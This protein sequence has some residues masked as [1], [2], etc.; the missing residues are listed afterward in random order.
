MSYQKP[1]YQITLSI[2]KSIQDISQKLGEANTLNLDK[3]PTQ[4]RKNNRIKSIFSSLSIEGN[5]L[6]LD[7][8]TSIV[9]DKR[10]LGPKL[11]IKEVKNAIQVYN[12]LPS[13]K[14]SKKTDLLRAH[15]LL[16][17]GLISNAGKFRTKSVGIAKGGQVEH[18]AP[19]SKLVSGQIANLLKYC[20]DK[21]EL[22]LIKSCVFHYDFEFIHPFSDGNGRM[23]RLWQTLIL[24]QEFPIFEFIP[25]ERLIKNNQAEY[26]QALSLS[27]KAGHSTP[28]IEYLLDRINE[29]LKELLDITH[30]KDSFESRMDK[31]Q[32]SFEQNQ[33][34][35]KDYMKL[36]KT[37]SSAKASRDL[38]KGVELK[39]L[40][41][42][43][44]K[45]TSV[46]V[47]RG[48]GEI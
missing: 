39:V 21:D 44:D 6:S 5:S 30:I 23:G 38:K 35:R 14:P 31:A 42:E 48:G 26:Y 16:M 2:L 47:F 19:P 28:F 12:L 24:M 17:N 22:T 4:L 18:I 7:Q 27:D 41:K 36:Y 37:I 9:D 34:T 25:I 15:K 45:R 43:G 10:V 1:P 33:F 8:I 29:A 13:L 20:K 40:V 11:D 32:S 3:P 46:Y